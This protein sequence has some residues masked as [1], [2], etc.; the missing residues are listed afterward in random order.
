MIFH[1][2]FGIA[3]LSTLILLAGSEISFAQKQNPAFKPPEKIDPNLPN[4]LIIGDSISIGYM[5]PLRTKLKGVANVFRPATN[6]GPST[7]GLDQIEKWIG[8]RKWDVIQFN[9]GLHDLKYMGPKGQNLADPTAA[10]SHQQ[11]PPKQY[12]E[13]LKKLAKRLKKT[14]ATVIFCE[15]TP[16]PKGA[17]GRVVGDSKKYNEIARAVMNEEGVDVNGLYAFAIQNA[18]TRPANVHYTSENSNKLAGYLA[19]QIVNALQK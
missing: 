5:V 12:A 16:V 4:V 11:V 10:G 18:P 2:N 17:S 9:H 8:D 7:R 14:G 15:T 13:N 1:T 3:V 6:C 19:D